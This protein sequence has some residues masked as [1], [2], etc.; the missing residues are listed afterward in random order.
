MDKTRIKY[1]IKNNKLTLLLVFIITSII[2][3][4]YASSFQ[5][6]IKNRG[7]QEGRVMQQEEIETLEKA[8]KKIIVHIS[9]EVVNPGIVELDYGQRLYEAI[10]IAGGSTEEADIGQVNLAMIVE[11]QQKIVIPS[12]NEM[13]PDGRSIAI[14]ENE[15]KINI[16]T[17]DKTKLMELPR[18]GEVTAESIIQ[19]REENY[20]FKNIEE[21]KNVPRI[22]DVTYEGLKDQVCCY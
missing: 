5:S 21:L 2:L 15:G 18:V 6:L 3:I 10:E 22:G 7:D 1:W 19:Y 17:A 13:T 9:G 20:G 16:N 8:E 11:D 12:M 14:P 4:Y